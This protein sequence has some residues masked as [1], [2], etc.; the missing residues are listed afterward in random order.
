MV[1]EEVV[2]NEEAATQQTFDLK[3]MCICDIGEKFI[4][5]YYFFITMWFWFFNSFVIFHFKSAIFKKS[6]S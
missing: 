4:C 2:V 5:N 3:I 6:L 1:Q